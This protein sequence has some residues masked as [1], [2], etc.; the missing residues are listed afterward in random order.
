MLKMQRDLIHRLLK[1]KTAELEE[2]EKEY[3]RLFQRE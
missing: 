2:Y 3:M 1:E